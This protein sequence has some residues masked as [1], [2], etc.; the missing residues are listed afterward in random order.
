MP[1]NEQK[2]T[3]CMES[4]ATKR[5]I[6]KEDVEKNRFPDSKTPGVHRDSAPIGGG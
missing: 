6:S 5:K 1:K 4:P 2:K 3:V